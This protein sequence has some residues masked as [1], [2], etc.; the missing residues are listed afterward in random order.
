MVPFDSDEHDRAR[1]LLVAKYATKE[2]DLAQW[3]AT[4]YPVAIALHP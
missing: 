2:D 3:R 4:A 1:D